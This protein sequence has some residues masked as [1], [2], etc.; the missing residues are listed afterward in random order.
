[1]IEVSSD[2][3]LGGMNTTAHI[4]HN[5]LSIQELSGQELEQWSYQQALEL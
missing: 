4:L 3:P 5:I 2:V 1:M